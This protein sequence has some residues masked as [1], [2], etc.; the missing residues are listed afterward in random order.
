MVA[1]YHL[2][3]TAYGFWLPNDIRG[4]T[5][6]QLR[7][8]KMSP[9]GDIH[10]GRKQ[11]QPSSRELQAFLKQAQE[12]LTHPVLTLDEE[13][14]LLVGN[15]IGEVIPERKYTCYACAVMPDHVHLLIR[16]H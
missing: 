10:L 13:S 11:Q 16:R 3:W 8:A 4:S 9:L 2:I 15:A 1:G 12:I 7:V 5:S 14:I 6:Q